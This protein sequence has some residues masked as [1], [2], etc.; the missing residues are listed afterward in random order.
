MTESRSS[1]SVDWSG[2]RSPGTEINGSSHDVLVQKQV[3]FI[4]FE[5]KIDNRHVFS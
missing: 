4:F 3:F 2:T 1:I 5:E